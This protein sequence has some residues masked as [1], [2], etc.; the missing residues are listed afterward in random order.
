M[1]LILYF[2]FLIC[3]T[4][5]QSAEV[6]QSRPLPQE[7]KILLADMME[8]IEAK[9]ASSELRTFAEQ[10]LARFGCNDVTI[11]E[12]DILSKKSIQPFII[13][14]HKF[15]AVHREIKHRPYEFLFALTCFQFLNKSNGI[16]W[17]KL[18]VTIAALSSVIAMLK[19]NMTIIERSACTAFI[20]LALIVNEGASVNDDLQRDLWVV[21]EL[22]KQGRFEAL[23]RAVNYYAS[24]EEENPFISKSA[25]F[26]RLAELGVSLRDQ[27]K[28]SQEVDAS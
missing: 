13:S 22:I 5:I 18:I 28:V 11:L 12:L 17:K 23:V 3:V 27:A 4:H 2:S 19:T 24:H 21:D 20:A 1:S 9:Q 14:G 6:P 7:V 26:K 15:L 16:S 8:A 10:E 25:I